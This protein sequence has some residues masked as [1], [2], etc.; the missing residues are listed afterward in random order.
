MSDTWQ[1]DD[2]AASDASITTID[3]AARLLAIL[4]AGEA[5]GMMLTEIARQ[6]GFGKGTTHRVLAALVEVGFVFQSPENRRYR[7]G[8][9]LT[10]MAQHARTQELAFRV[11]PLL[12]R[13]A[14]QTGDTAFCSIREGLSA[15]CIA[16]ATGEFPI[17]TLTLDV[18]S[19]RPLGIGAGSLALLAALPD[20]LVQDSLAKNARLLAAYPVYSPEW[21][22]GRVR[23]ARECGYAE[24]PGDILP[25]MGAI[26][27]V[28]GDPAFQPLAALSIAAISERVSP[29]RKDLLIGKLREA[30]DELTSLMR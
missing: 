15:V 16:R 30:T 6:A 24:N 18:G 22:M 5:M 12:D 9:R 17:R 4:A 28:V 10:L 3:R 21:L 26:G 11:Q 20:A 8:S 23:E 7:L 2:E 29:P 27:M 25:G 13:L 19:R 14:E 1:Q